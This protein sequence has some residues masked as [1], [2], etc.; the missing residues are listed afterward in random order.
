MYRITLV[1]ISV[2]LLAEAADADVIATYDF[3]GG[4]L[5][6]TN[7]LFGTASDITLGANWSAAADGLTG[8]GDN[9]TGN[10]N[11]PANGFSFNFTVSGLAAGETLALDSASI[12]LTNSVG[13]TRV[14]FSDTGTLQNTN[15]GLGDGNFTGPLTSTGLTNGS[16]VTVLFGY[17]DGNTGAGQTYTLDNVV[18]NGTVTAAAV[19]EPCSF[20]VLAGCTG[21]GFLRAR[22]RRRRLSE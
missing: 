17:R 8:L 15:P 12:D 18:L 6:A 22:R 2:L 20:A 16:V 3:N 1:V 13:S 7:E 10:I 5:A 21:L 19:P 9:I 14:D 4:S 11:T